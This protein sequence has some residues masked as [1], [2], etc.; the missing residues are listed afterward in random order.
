M[1]R[2]KQAKKNRHLKSTLKLFKR[3]VLAAP[4]PILLNYD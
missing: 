1:G 2:V 4:L 3:W